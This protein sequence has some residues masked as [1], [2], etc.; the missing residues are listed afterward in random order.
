MVPPSQLEWFWEQMVQ[1]AAPPR[2]VFC[3]PMPFGFRGVQNL[4]NSSAQSRGRLSPFSPDRL[5]D[6]ENVLSRNCIDGLA[7]KG[8]GILARVIRHCALCLA[9]RK[10]ADKVSQTS[11][12]ISPNV[13]TPPSRLRS[14]MGLRPF[15][16]VRRASAAFSRASAS[17]TSFALPR[18]ISL[19]APRHVKRRTHFREPVSETIKYRL[20]PSLCLPGFAVATLRAE[21]RPIISHLAGSVPNSVPKN[22][23]VLCGWKRTT[24]IGSGNMS[25]CYWASG[26]CRRTAPNGDGREVRRTPS[27]PIGLARRPGGIRLHKRCEK[28]SFDSEKQA[29]AEI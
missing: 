22:N 28:P 12:A 1:M 10:P 17:G 3:S 9:L 6:G 23:T 2:R 15:E 14:S 19:A 24:A 25:D 13:G 21:R 4:L 20:P 26:R 8:P 29:T 27:P 5:E 16:R 18:P 7:S 11:S